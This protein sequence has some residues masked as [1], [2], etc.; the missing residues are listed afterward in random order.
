MEE[1]LQVIWIKEENVRK[2][3][4]FIPHDIVQ[5]HKYLEQKGL[6]FSDRNFIHVMERVK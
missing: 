1:T 6:V 4:E 5:H 3:W 2:N